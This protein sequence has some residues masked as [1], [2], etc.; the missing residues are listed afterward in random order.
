MALRNTKTSKLIP[1][2]LKTVF[3]VDMF[4]SERSKFTSNTHHDRSITCP[5]P[6]KSSDLCCAVLGIVIALPTVICISNI[7]IG[8]HHRHANIPTHAENPQ[9][10]LRNNRVEVEQVTDTTWDF[11]VQITST[12][13]Y[14][15]LYF[16][17]GHT[18]TKQQQR[19]CA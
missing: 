5:E 11:F 7:L 3:T 9:L 16:Q 12:E 13:F 8:G 10:I 4:A 19:I 1:V 14:M 6:I 18:E 2:R 17:I 15:H